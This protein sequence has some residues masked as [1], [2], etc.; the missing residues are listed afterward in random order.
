MFHFPTLQQ[1]PSAP[2]EEKLEPSSKENVSGPEFVKGTVLGLRCLNTTVTRKDIKVSNALPPSV[3]DPHVVRQ[4][5]TKLF[6][7]FYFH[8]S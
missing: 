1:T 6:M 3:L 5:A 7:F 8:N 4:G 2:I